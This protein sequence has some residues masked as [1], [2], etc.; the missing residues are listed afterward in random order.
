M[1]PKDI[2]MVIAYTGIGK[3]SVC[4][5]GGTGSGWL[6]VSLARVAKSVTSYESRAEFAKLA[7]KNAKS[8]RLRNLII[9]NADITKTVRERDVDLVTLDMP[10]AERAL[11]NAFAALKPD[12]YVFGYLPHMEQ[13][14]RF[15]ERMEKL[16]FYDIASYEIIAREMLVREEGTRPSTKGVWHTGYL[17]FGKRPQKKGRDG[18]PGKERT[19]KRIRRS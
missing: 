12:G 5:D 18:K 4:L 7:Q 13:M 2:G 19:R 9:K 11:K 8:E 10:N 14:K 17:V 3:R 1:L 16:R 15:V 6:A